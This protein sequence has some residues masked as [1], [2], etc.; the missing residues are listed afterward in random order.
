MLIPSPF[1][2]YKSSFFSISVLISLA[3]ATFSIESAIASAAISTRVVESV[4]NATVVILKHNANVNIKTILFFFFS[5]TIFSFALFR[6]TSK[7]H[8]QSIPI[9][10]C[11]MRKLQNS[12]SY[13]PS[14][15]RLIRSVSHVI[16]SLP[17]HSLSPPLNFL[18]FT[19]IKAKK[20]KNVTVSESFLY[21]SCIL[22]PAKSRLLASSHLKR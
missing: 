15:Y 20:F 3:P 17:I 13:F 7:T 11:K 14:E 16:I 18:P 12:H 21:V 8:A 5:P 19:Y 1:A 6:I 22:F 9:R 2:R 4:A 10:F